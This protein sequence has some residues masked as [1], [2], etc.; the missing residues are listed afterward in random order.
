MQFKV[1]QLYR[2]PILQFRSSKIRF[3]ASDP[4][5]RKFSF[6]LPGGQFLTDK[7]NL[8]DIDL[9]VVQGGLHALLSKTHNFLNDLNSPLVKT[10]KPLPEKDSDRNEDEDL[11]VTEYT[12]QSKTPNGKLSLAAVISIERFSRMNGLSAKKM[13]K[14]FQAMVPSPMHND[15]RNWVEFCCFRF[16]SRDN[17]DIH[18]RLKD[19]VFQKLIFITMIAW[20]NPYEENHN[21]NS[22]DKAS[23]RDSLKKIMSEIV[24]EEAFVRIA[25]AVSGVADR[26]TAHNLFKS[27]A[28]DGRGISLSTWSSYVQELLQVH[29]S[30]KSLKIPETPHLHSEQVLCTSSRRLELV[31]LWDD[32]MAWPGKLTLTD[33]ALYFESVNVFGKKSC[34]RLDIAGHGSKA[35]KKRNGPLESEVLDSAVTVSS[36]VESKAWVLEFI[37]VGG[38]MRRDIWHAYISE[39][40]ALHNFIREY[41]PEEDDPLVPH[42]YGAHKGNGRANFNA[43]SSINRLKTVQSVGKLL[44]DP[45]K[46]VQFSYLQ[47]SPYGDVVFQAL[48]LSCWGGPFTSKSVKGSKSVKQGG[49]EMAAAEESFAHVYDL[50]GSAYLKQ[51]MQSPSWASRD[52]LSFWRNISTRG[53][54]LS[55]HLVVADTSILEKAARICRYR[56]EAVE[57]TQATIDSAKLEGIPSNI[58]LFKELVLP[59]SIAV[60]NFEKLRRWEKPVLTLSFLGFAYTAILRNLL[61]F[62]F[63]ATLITVGV[64]MLSLKGLKERGLLRKSLETVIL[65]DQAPSNTIQKIIAIK[66]AMRDTENFLQNLNVSLLKMRTIILSGQ[67]QITTEVA[68]VLLSTGII[69]LTVPLKYV[70]SCI[71]FD[72]FTRELGFRREMA[73]KFTKLLKERWDTI[74]AAPVITVPFERLRVS[75]HSFTAILITAKS[76]TGTLAPYGFSTAVLDSQ[77]CWTAVPQVSITTSCF[78]IPFTAKRSNHHRQ[79]ESSNKANIIVVWL[80]QE[81]VT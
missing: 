51:W 6:K 7:F 29:E 75:I 73:A 48:A 67:P 31:L 74:H 40:I 16:L 41:G 18:I 79:V 72:L 55:K 52:S 71:L 13:Q 9:G 8:K 42:V 66:K 61:R 15:A 12:I 53:V 81:S 36:V 33:R 54:V 20:E 37:D 39:V 64:M 17:S 80:T 62:V 2:Q 4:S 44:D 58:D 77:I 24:G 50:D 14:I 43:T 57:Q 60:L 3:S 1:L 34:R 28:R 11:L 38:E 69:L 23:E 10:G 63:P 26:P 22:Q 35:E 32:K 47:S 56:C 46:L 78:A 65:H 27:L 76:I 5:G 68:L 45:C 70:L 25:P 49:Q 30:N 59:F 21:T 19:P